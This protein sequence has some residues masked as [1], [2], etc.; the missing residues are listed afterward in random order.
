MTTK[1]TDTIDM[2]HFE[3]EAIKNGFVRIA[4][5]DEVGRGPLAG[6]VVVAA[7]VLPN[8]SC[9]LP[10]VDSKKLT[11]KRREKLAKEIRSIPKVD[12][13]IVTLEAEE[14]DKLNIL[15]AT[16]KAMRLALQNLENGAEFALVDGLPVP[17]LPI[18]ANFI[19]KG[20]GRSLSIAAASIIAKV[21]RDALMV[22][23]DDIYPGYN[24]S[25]HKGYGTKVHLQALKKLGPCPIH[26]RSF[27]PVREADPELKKQLQFNF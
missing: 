22:K 17:N 12:I 15:K 2:L 3:H 4:G 8:G 14:V 9:E 6:P 19:I 25:A 18:E 21:Y 1:K 11:A 13:S 5:V 10:L 23:Y 16:H 27:A 24:F 26:R 20:D 7:V